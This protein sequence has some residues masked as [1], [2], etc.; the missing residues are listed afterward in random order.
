MKA[1]TWMQR[2]VMGGM[3]SDVYYEDMVF[4]MG[5]RFSSL[6]EVRCKLTKCREP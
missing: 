2:N 3:I 1:V 5:H 4:E 6:P